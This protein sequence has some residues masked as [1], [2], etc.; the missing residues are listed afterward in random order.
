MTVL[1]RSST[2]PIVRQS[3]IRGT[4]S[5]VVRPEARSDAAMSL[6]AEFFAPEIG[7]VPE[8]RCPPSMRSLSAMRGVLYPGRIAARTSPATNNAPARL[9][10]T[11]AAAVNHSGQI[12]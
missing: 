10:C 1:P 6:S 11:N 7:T 3:T 12:G 4:R 9:A 5:S 8:R 2:S